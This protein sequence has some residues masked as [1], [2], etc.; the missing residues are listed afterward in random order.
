MLQ[1]IEDLTIQASDKQL[2]LIRPEMNDYSMFAIDKLP[3]I[4]QLGYDQMASI[5]SK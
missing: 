5:W 3:E 4:V 1:R 2:I